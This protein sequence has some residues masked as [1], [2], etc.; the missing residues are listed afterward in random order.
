M[1]QKLEHLV[2]RVKTAKS[3]TLKVYLLTNIQ[4]VILFQS[5]QLNDIVVSILEDSL[6]E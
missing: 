4:I 6:K 2:I 3:Q 1:K 5:E